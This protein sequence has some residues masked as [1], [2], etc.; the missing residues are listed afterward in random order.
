MPASRPS[1]SGF[2]LTGPL[3]CLSLHCTSAECDS[4]RNP[5]VAALLEKYVGR[6]S[7]EFTVQASI[8]DE[9]PGVTRLHKQP[10]PSQ[11]F[12]SACEPPAVDT[13]GPHQARD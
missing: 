13:S 5:I 9:R 11:R 4:N 12:I 8:R 6:E 10:T 3:Y 1:P 7:G 2:V